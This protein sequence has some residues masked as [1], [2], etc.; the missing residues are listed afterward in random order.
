VVP[1][2]SVASSLKLDDVVQGLGYVLGDQIGRSN[3]LPLFGL[4]GELANRIEGQLL[5]EMGIADSA[6]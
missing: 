6:A 5:T 2:V 1:G 3:K 4:A